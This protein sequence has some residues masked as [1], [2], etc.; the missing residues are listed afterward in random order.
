MQTLRNRPLLRPVHAQTLPGSGRRR[1]APCQGQP[2]TWF[3]RV[4]SFVAKSTV[5][6]T[7]VPAAW[8]DAAKSCRVVMFSLSTQS[9]LLFALSPQPFTVT[10]V[11]TEKL[12]PTPPCGSQARNC[13]RLSNHPI[14]NGRVTIGEVAVAAAR[15]SSESK[16]TSTCTSIRCVDRSPFFG[17]FT[18]ICSWLTGWA[19][20]PLQYATLCNR[21]EKVLFSLQGHPTYEFCPSGSTN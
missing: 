14:D 15:P 5:S 3:L 12:R 16:S 21:P 17:R 2:D 20:F 10:C 18:E 6:M 13:A 7:F 11:R 8:A 19:Q 1:P 9:R 4:H